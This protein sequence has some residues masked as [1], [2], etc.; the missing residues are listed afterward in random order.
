MLHKQIARDW[1][2]WDIRAALGKKGYTLAKVA[3]DNGYAR[4]SPNEALRKPWPAM[5]R[6]IADIIGVQP[7]EIWP[8]RYDD[9]HRPLRGLGSTMHE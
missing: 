6:I 3:R 7:W 1:H 5:E 2:N 4:T 8:T 9:Q